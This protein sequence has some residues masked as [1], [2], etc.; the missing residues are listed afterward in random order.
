MKKL[1]LW[2]FP[3]WEQREAELVCLRAQ[4]ES[5]RRREQD[6]EH[7]LRMSDLAYVKAWAEARKLR[8]Q[9]QT[10]RYKPGVSPGWKGP[11][12]TAQ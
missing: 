3:E 7:R 5:L 12:E 1:L 10:A 8:E 4:A 9:L 11:K 6:L 2:L